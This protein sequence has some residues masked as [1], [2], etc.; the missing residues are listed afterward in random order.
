MLKKR[1]VWGIATY[2]SLV[3]FIVGCGITTSSEP[4]IEE[5]ATFSGDSGANTSNLNLPEG[6][7]PIGRQQEPTQSVAATEEPSD[8]VAGTPEPDELVANTPITDPS[9]ITI[10]QI[11]LLATR[12]EGE[13]AQIQQWFY[14]DNRSNQDYIYAE[15]DNSSVRLPLPPG[16]DNISSDSVAHQIITDGP[17]PLFALSAPFPAQTE[18]QLIIVNYTLPYAQF[19]NLTYQANYATD[20]FTVYTPLNLTPQWE[21]PELDYVGTRLIRGGLGDFLAFRRTNITPNEA[22]AFSI[23][24]SS[25]LRSVD[26]PLNRT[27]EVLVGNGT[28]LGPIPSDL[29][30]SLSSYTSDQQ[31][32]IYENTQTLA[33]PSNRF[34]DVPIVSGGTVRATVNY[35]G[36]EYNG[37]L[38][39]VEALDG[40]LQLNLMIYEPTDDPSV[41][42]LES[43]L[44]VVDAVTAEG[45]A[46]FIVVFTIRN[47]SDNIF[48]GNSE[49]L[50][51]ILRIPLPNNAMSISPLTEDPAIFIDESGPLPMIV[52]NRPIDPHSSQSLDVTFLLEYNG[53]TTLTHNFGFAAETVAVFTAQSRFLAF[54][55]DGFV[56]DNAYQIE[57]LGFYNGYFKEN[58]PANAV[59]SF[60]ISDTE[61]TPNLSSTVETP[62]V[63]EDT[64]TTPEDEGFLQENSN[65]I[66]GIGVL[67]I[68]FGSVY[69]VY[70]LQ[71]ERI[72]A[73][74]AIAQADSSSTRK[75]PNKQKSLVQAIA[76]LDEKYEQ[77]TIEESDYL[78]QRNE[79][80]AKLRKL[81]DH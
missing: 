65:F 15:G 20:S 34:V 54:E 9:V 19:S 23:Q 69:F 2:I 56:F 59:L 68:I 53:A 36:V 51:E 22:V 24:P 61:S 4:P 41:L 50:G 80:K 37:S 77:G 42:T 78:Q 3:L 16:A 28:P 25:Q 57:G 64:T 10:T 55:G 70:D 26:D 38:T 45:W 11:W 30:V 7:P 5:E 47:D 48:M 17:L 46:E 49:T 18:R 66:L 74:V 71:K 13:V 44:Y 21:I 67:M 75:L 81:M 31:T 6:H 29:S 43:A 8:G 39:G 52:D 63:L 73:R 40:K 35:K 14:L 12:F 60:M 79:L 1:H 32:S 33:F 58:H 72:R 62:R 76:D 27:V